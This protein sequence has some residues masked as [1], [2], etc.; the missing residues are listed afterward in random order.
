MKKKIIKILIGSCVAIMIVMSYVASIASQNATQTKKIIKGVVIEKPVRQP[1]K[2][3]TLEEMMASMG[4]VEG[5]GGPGGGPSAA[6]GSGGPGGPGGGGPG[7][8]PGA[9]GR[10]GAASTPGVYIKDG[11]FSA[12]DSKKEAVTAGEIK[13]TYATGVKIAAKEGTT[14][15]VYVKGI[16]SEY[17]L[18]DANIELSGNGT[19][20]GGPGSGAAS[21]DH[22]TL[23]IKN[24]NITT[25]GVAR[26]ATSATNYSTLKV[27]NST[28]T[29]H[30]V[31][32]DQSQTSPPEHLE[33]KGNSRTHVTMS[34][35]Y[36]YFYYSTIVADGWAALST[37]GAEGFVYLEADNCKVKT[38]NSGYGTYADGACH[39][40]FNNCDFDV[41]SMAA[42]IAGEADC[43]FRDT[44]AKCGT[45]FAMIHC[46]MGMPA[47]VSTLKVTGGEISCK[48]PA[49]IVNSQN[50]IINFDGVKINSESGVLVKSAV[51]D[52]PNATKT[53]GQKVYGI[54]TTLKGMDVAGN[55]VHEDPDRNMYVYLASTN[56][57]GAIKDAY[58]TIDGLSKWTATADSKVTIVGSV[59]LSQIDAPTGVRITAAA[60]ESG[61]Y[62]L[63][64]GGTLILK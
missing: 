4:G 23:I 9:G 36:S 22:S 53:K 2:M 54:H 17:I 28:L 5:R 41:A 59:D 14:G 29:A 61:T 48:S 3:P 34:N 10:G 32:F 37:D 27:F 33:I 52:D 42:I 30:G 58:V 47:E 6:G 60:G 56:L 19:G 35:S 45:Y 12:G 26:S 39:N 11:K 20:L 15:G 31:P 7:G 25:S 43:T 64:S 16:G 62:T 13:D 44:L 24:A 18:S 46:V 8:A 49:V 21:D 40:Y 38:I 51:N 63:A 1:F 57:K 55:V 50:A